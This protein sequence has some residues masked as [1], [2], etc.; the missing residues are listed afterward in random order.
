MVCKLKIIDVKNHRL[1]NTIVN[2]RLLFEVV[3]DFILLGNVSPLTPFLGLNAYSKI[4]NPTPHMIPVKTI[5]MIK[6]DK[7]K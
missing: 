4:N 5:E 6:S 1:K 7:C 2:I 3:L